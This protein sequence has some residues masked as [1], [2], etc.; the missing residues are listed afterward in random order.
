MA[1]AGSS[2][3][4][5]SVPMDKLIEALAQVVRALIRDAYVRDGWLRCVV[6]IDGPPETITIRVNSGDDLEE[7]LGVVVKDRR[8]AAN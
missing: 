4:D 2:L 1:T 7:D 6:E 5:G 8:V 3:Y